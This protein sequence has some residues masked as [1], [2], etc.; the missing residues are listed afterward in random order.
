MA[1]HVPR[2]LLKQPDIDKCLLDGT[3]LWKWDEVCVSVC[4][5]VGGWAVDHNFFATFG[6]SPVAAL[7]YMSSLNAKLIK[8]S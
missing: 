8:S 6:Q 5:C 4:V 7:F 1:G 3:K 2:R